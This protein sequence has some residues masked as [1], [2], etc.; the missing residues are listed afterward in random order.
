[1]SGD[2]FWLPNRRITKLAIAAL[3]A[4]VCTALVAYADERASNRGSP[5]IDPASAPPAKRPGKATGSAKP[6]KEQIE[7]LIRD[8]GSPRFTARRAAASELRQIGAEAFDLLY[9]ATDDA[10]PEVAASANYL[11]RQ[12]PVRWVQ[13]DDAASVREMMRQYAQE[14]EPV[15]LQRVEMLGN[16]SGGVGNAALCRIARYDRSPLVSR[17]A[18]L[19]IIRPPEKPTG[20]SHTDSDVVER[21]LGSSTRVAAAWLRQYLSQL[22]D[23]AVSV[24]GWKQL[25]E[26]ESARL[27]K[28]VGDT[29]S[30]IMLGLFW[31]LADVYRQISDRPALN[32]ALDR[33]IGLAGEGSDDTLVNLLA[34][35][36]ENKSWEVL[37]VFITKHQSRLEQGKRPLY[38]AAMARAKQGKRELAEELATKAAALPSQS[39][40]LESLYAAKE[41]EEHRQF[42]WALREFRRAIDKQPGE[43]RE[44][45]LARIHLGVMLHDY[46]RDKEAAEAI[47]KLVPA[48]QG[49]GR[50][51]Q[52][53]LRIREYYGERSSLPPPEEV[54]KNYHFYRA[55]QYIHEKDY[56]RARGELD[57][58]ITFDPTDG[59]V[60]IEMYRLPESNA[61]WKEGVRARIRKLTQQ[62]QAEIDENPASSSPYNQ[63]AWLVSNTEG[64]FQQAVRYSHKSVEL[65]LHD[66]SKE[67]SFLDTLARCYYAAGDYANAV[68]YEREALAKV[69]H[70]QV[71]HRQLALF[72][73]ALAEKQASA[74]K[75]PS[76]DSN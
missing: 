14:S 13:S 31:N 19:V 40:A 75:Q 54:A 52:L 7:Q 20:E 66:D 28:N 2:V 23:P 3:F 11:L 22:R 32:G 42:D 27:E 39:N 9:A 5:A 59:D 29:S 60:L 73:K 45:I 16:L 56:Q 26:Q 62:F 71:M 48:A 15:R 6:T 4:C 50:L 49:Q 68:K 41:L 47:E 65:N 55:C 43:S 67:A 34:W 74:T 33:M 44:S 51:G 10:D 17:S 70:M 61:E 53:Y 1:M 18:A 25:I 12:I 36:T 30:D 37:D 24:V 58:A 46:E 72:E 21:E 38:F 63:W 76:N 35:L 69:D 8:L 64:D 57:Q